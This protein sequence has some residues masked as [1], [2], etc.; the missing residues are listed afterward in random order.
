MAQWSSTASDEAIWTNA[1]G[2]KSGENRLQFDAPVAP[3]LFCKSSYMVLGPYLLCSFY[4]R[5]VVR[6]PGPWRRKQ[7]FW[8]SNFPFETNEDVLE[9][10]RP[11]ALIQVSGAGSSGHLGRFRSHSRRSFDWRC[12]PQGC[13]RSE[14]YEVVV[15]LIR[16]YYLAG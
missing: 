8:A 12:R 1:P 4:G 16:A 7:H 2:F 14:Q 15:T 13:A 5:F 9:C 10:P 3:I 11:P 6:E